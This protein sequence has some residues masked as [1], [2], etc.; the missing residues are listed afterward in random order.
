MTCTKNPLNINCPTP[1]QILNYVSQKQF[2]VTLIQGMHQEFASAGAV[3][4]IKE[5][6]GQVQQVMSQRSAGSC[7]RR[8]RANAFPALTYNDFRSVRRKGEMASFLNRPFVAALESLKRS[9]QSHSTSTT[10][11]CEEL[12]HCTFRVWYTQLFLKLPFLELF[13]NWFINDIAR[14]KSVDI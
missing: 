11:T 3:C 13:F 12:S 4:F 10:H 1:A 9:Y 5:S 14:L 7:T 2:T 6:S 8:T